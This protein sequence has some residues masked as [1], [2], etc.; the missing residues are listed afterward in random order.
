MSS[1]QRL[2]ST[3]ALAFA[4][5]GVLFQA[6]AGGGYAVH[7]TKSAFADV[8]EGLQ[9]AIQER[10]MYINNVMHM[11]EM[12]ERT[13]RDLGLGEPVFLK[14]ESIEF[15]SAGLSHRMTHEN[16]ARVVN[17]PF[18]VAAYVLAKEPDKTYVVYREIPQDQIEASSVMAEVA[19]NLKGIAETGASW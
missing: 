18:I 9:S 5:T 12:L 3:L 6:Q 16:P 17:C 2:A 15:C 10:G 1:P 13:G 14:A 8:M 4:L 11:G 7:E 19:E